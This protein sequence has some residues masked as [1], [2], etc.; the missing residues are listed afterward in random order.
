MSITVGR[1]LVTHA[2]QFVALPITNLPP[3]TRFAAFEPSVPPI[4]LFLRI[5]SRRFFGAINEAQTEIDLVEYPAR[6]KRRG[7]QKMEPRG[8]EPLTS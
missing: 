2:L 4:W 8:L 6:Y 7:V 1:K 3:G 5:G